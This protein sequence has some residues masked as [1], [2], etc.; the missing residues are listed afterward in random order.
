MI[1]VVI[2]AHNEEEYIE[3]CLLS[4]F[5]AAR[6][7]LLNE[8]PVVV[9]VVLDD[10]Q[11]RTEEIA[12]KLGAS[13]A[14]VNFRNVGSTRAAGA[15]LMIERGAS[16]LAF[17]DADTLVPADWLWRQLD[18][19]TDAVCGIV[20]VDS[21]SKYG[22][23]VR[24]HYIGLYQFT[25]NHR[26]VHGANLGVSVTAYSRAGGFQALATHE[27]VRL[28][29]DLEAT[30]ACIVWTATNPVRTSARTDYRC[31]EGFGEYLANL[32]VSLG[33]IRDDPASR[34]SAEPIG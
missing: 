31:E 14:K 11:D 30:G 10:C 33:V 4:V 8:T 25:E 34:E 20:E 29:T 24:D 16:W 2:P 23:K 28:V 1:G 32:A 18:F 17:T 9:T 12:L 19:K 15:D 21:W 26:H 22:K 3:Q 27:D 5:D 13:V 7:P 6:H